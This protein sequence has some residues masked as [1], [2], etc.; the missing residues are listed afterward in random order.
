MA[1]TLAAI[2]VPT[3]PSKLGILYNLVKKI[4]LESMIFCRSD[5]DSNSRTSLPGSRNGTPEPNKIFRDKKEAMEAF[6]EFLKE[7]VRTEFLNNL[8]AIA[9]INTY[10]RKSQVMPLGISVSV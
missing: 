7:K 2:D 1:A 9:L 10:I 3:P 8:G 5:D 4:V 6:K